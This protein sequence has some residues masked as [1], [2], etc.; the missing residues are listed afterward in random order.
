MGKITEALRKAAEDRIE[1]IDKIARIHEQK[2]LV[3]KKIGDSRVDPRLVT[4]F[5]PKALITEQY[6]ILRTNILSTNAKR[7]LKTLVITSSL[8]SEGK[9]VTALNLAMVIAQSTQKPK[10]LVVDADMRRGRLAKYLGVDHPTGLTEILTDKAGASE[11]L[12]HID[13]EN[14]AFIAAGSVAENPAELLG[15]DKMRQFLADMKAQFDF[16]LIDTPPIIA[17]TDPG[18]VG[19]LV[20]GILMTIQAGRT[21]RGVIRR[22]TELL[23]QSQSKIIG[24]VLTNIEYHLPEYI[25]RYL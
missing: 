11:A 14:L 5:D 8:H 4:Y 13:M 6:K 10:V 17:V 12:F 19:A 21:Q 7:S 9:T 1:R 22:A 2:A 25:Y 23:E 20:D 24:H 18:I 3:I 16:I 15:S